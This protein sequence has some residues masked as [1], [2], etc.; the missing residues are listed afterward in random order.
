MAEKWLLRLFESW[1]IF[2]YLPKNRS[3]V[4]SRHMPLIRTSDNWKRQ[5]PVNMMGVVGH[6][7]YS[8]PSRFSPVLQC[9]AC[10]NNFVVSTWIAAVFISMVGSNALILINHDLLWWFHSVWTAYN[11]LQQ[12]IPPN[13]E[14]MLGNIVI[15]LWWWCWYTV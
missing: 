1:S 14:Q 9:M 6:S 4:Q 5:C 15:W 12:L 7:I 2:W 11:K 3:T 13:A 8:F 10:Y